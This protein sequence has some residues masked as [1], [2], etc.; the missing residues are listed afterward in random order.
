M[1]GEDAPTPISQ[2]SYAG[3][4]IKGINIYFRD[5]DASPTRLNGTAALTY[6]PTSHSVRPVSTRPRV[7]LPPE[8]TRSQKNR[9]GVPSRLMEEKKY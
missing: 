3:C 9:K 6:Q 1:I 5:V 7:Q 4:E 2:S 8:H